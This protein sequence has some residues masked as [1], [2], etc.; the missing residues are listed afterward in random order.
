MG[1]SYEVLNTPIYRSVEVRCDKHPDNQFQPKMHFATQHILQHL[2]QC[3][4]S[5]RTLWMNPISRKVYPTSIT[6]Q[7]VPD[8]YWYCHWVKLC[9]QCRT[10][11]QHMPLTVPDGKGTG[12]WQNN[13]IMIYCCLFCHERANDYTHRLYRT[14]SNPLAHLRN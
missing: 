12:P 8:S 1:V 7:K 14:S 11:Y 13:I 2:A 3:R 9:P 6:S 4:I 10:A 5:C